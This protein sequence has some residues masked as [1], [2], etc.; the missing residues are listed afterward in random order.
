VA[1]AHGVLR[2]VRNVPARACATPGIECALAH[3][4]R[5][6]FPTTPKPAASP[7]RCA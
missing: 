3:S 4:C 2:W 1:A 7:C 5:A 6:R